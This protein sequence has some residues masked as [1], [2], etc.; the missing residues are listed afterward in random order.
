MIPL[1]SHPVDE[2]NGAAEG[3]LRLGRIPGVHGRAYGLEGAAQPGSK[4]PVVFSLLD[5]LAVCFQR[6]CVSSHSS[7]SSTKRKSGPAGYGP[8]TQTPKYITDRAGVP[9]PL[10]P[11][12]HL[13]SFQTS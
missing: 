4:L 7:E 3:F 10:L 5:A 1:A 11:V 2:R 9:T 6:G 12:R 13:V 8:A